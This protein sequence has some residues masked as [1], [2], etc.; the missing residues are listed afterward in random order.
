MSSLSGITTGVLHF[1]TKDPFRYPGTSVELVAGER[2]TFKASVR[3]AGHSE[4]NTFG[5]KI[6]AAY[7]RSDDWSLDPND[8]DDAVMQEECAGR[9]IDADDGAGVGDRQPPSR[10]GAA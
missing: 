6:N 2:S 8:P 10:I 5:Y 7:R 1:L 4:D 3:H 9:F